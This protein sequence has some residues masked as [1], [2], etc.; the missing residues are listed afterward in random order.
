ME[1]TKQVQGKSWGMVE[2]I[3][4]SCQTFIVVWGKSTMIVMRETAFSDFLIW[5]GH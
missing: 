3:Y 2:K 1:Q 5:E 4:Y